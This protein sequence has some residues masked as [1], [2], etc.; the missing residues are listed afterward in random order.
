MSFRVKSKDKDSKK[1]AAHKKNGF[2]E[3]DM[4][5]W[6]VLDVS[7]WLASLEL[8]D[9]IPA[10]VE[11]EISGGELKTLNDADLT[12]LGVTKIGHRKKILAIVN[13]S[14]LQTSTNADSESGPKSKSTLTGSSDTSS[15]IAIKAT[16]K[17]ETRKMKL[18]A[19]SRLSDL[20]AEVTAK[21][22]LKN[23]KF[24]LCYEDAD[25]DML[26]LGSE[27]EWEE[28]LNESPK[29]VKLIIRESGS[30]KDKKSSSSKSKSKSSSSSSSISPTVAFAVF[31]GL[32]QATLVIDEKG[33]LQYANSAA[34]KS[35]GY[36][37][38][39]MIG[40]NVKMLMPE[41]FARE[42]DSYLANYIRTGNAK[43]IGTGRNVTMMSKDGMYVPI[44]LQVTENN[45]T[46][47]RM[48]VGTITDA[49]E[50]R[51]TQTVLSMVR[52]VLDT[53][54][55]PAVAITDKGIIQVFNKPAQ[56]LWGYSLTEV[57]GKN[58]KML[59]P[60]DYAIHHDQYIQ[61]Y[62]TTGKAKI[63]GTGRDVVALLKDGTL[64]NVHLSISER[65]DGEGS[66]FT[67]VLAVK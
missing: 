57:V 52:E 2:K 3:K 46:G 66:I 11:N 16:Y 4:N 64:R 55:N 13:P 32:L 8:N 39:E 7:D 47:K 59:M 34:E 35:T 33:I 27:S 36:T 19:G 62:L 10:F 22:E 56:Q 21:F 53:L 60:E 67:G 45:V 25:G 49:R 43:V 30:S 38:S 44:F 28:C 23:M 65:K 54:V 18:A 24:Q 58:V 15:V 17:G 29:S 42:H 40:K 48:F 50:E 26:T 9:L 31:D 12:S 51:K 20:K 61:S 14:V 63:I 41:E 5:F 37:R 6:S 1:E